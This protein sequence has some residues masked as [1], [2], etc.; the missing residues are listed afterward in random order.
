MVNPPDYSSRDWPQ[1]QRNSFRE[2]VWT[3]W[4][5]VTDLTFYSF[6]LTWKG[7]AALFR[8]EDQIGTLA[9]ANVKPIRYGPRQ[10]EGYAVFVPKR[11]TGETDL[12]AHQ[13]MRLLDLVPSEGSTAVRVLTYPV[14]GKAKAAMEAETYRRQ[15]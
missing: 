12:P 2:Y 5:Q 11:T 4:R 15:P 13:E 10:K 3:I 9:Y 14:T 8:F 1:E 7:K 6:E